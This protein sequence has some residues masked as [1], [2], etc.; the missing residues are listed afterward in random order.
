VQ[1]FTRPI[2]RE[3]ELAG[4]RLALTLTENG[5][6]VR[7]VG[8]RK[9]PREIHWSALLCYLMSGASA[10]G[11]PTPEAVAAAVQAMKA[12][13]PPSPP[14]AAPP[15]AEKETAP[16]P[17]ATPP[18]PANSGHAPAHVPASGDM[19]A[20]LARL[21]RWLGEHRRRYLEGLAPGATAAELEDVQKAVGGPLPDA[22]RSFLEWHN[23]QD[24]EF[25]GRFRESWYLMD[26][27]Q[28]VS[29]WQE[30]VGSAEP[31]KWQRGW[32]PFLEDDR[33]NYVF[34]DTTQAGPP[35]REFWEHN[36]EQP[37]VAPTLAAWLEELI[38]GMERGEYAEDPERGLF[39]R[40]AK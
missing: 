13:A 28:I 39:M 11:E 3:I 19:A 18:A 32:V 40:R 17:P 5:V 24:D 38:S 8:S 26:T 33:G 31:T 25:A 10:I 21:A 20:L 29:A 37:V 22:L 30:L 7:L 4:E 36:P 6:Q 34:L 1:K 12:G 2:T 27:G 9:P 16:T 14:P 23:G 15:V 35:V